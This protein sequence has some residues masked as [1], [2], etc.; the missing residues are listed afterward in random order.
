M[1]IERLDLVAFGHFTDDVIDLS[2]GPVRFHLVYGPNESGKSTSL[3]AIHSLLFGMPARSDDDFIHPYRSM[4]VGGRLVDSESG[5]AIDCV[6]RRGKKKTLLTPDEQS[7]LDPAKLA[8]MLR[9]V[10]SETFS[11]QFGISHAELVAGGRAILEGGGDLGEMLFAAGSGTGALRK[12]RQRLEEDMRE[13]FIPR[14]SRGALNRLLAEHQENQRQI[15][16]L[17]LLPRAYEEKL[18]EF[19]RALADAAETEAQLKAE[20]R[21]ERRLRAIAA[22]VERLPERESIRSELAAIGD[23]IP[24]LDDD[25]RERRRDLQEEWSDI[26]QSVATH[27]QHAEDLQRQRDAQPLDPGWNEVAPDIKRLMNQLSEIESEEDELTPLRHE[28]QRAEREADQTR[29]RLAANDVDS[30]TDGGNNPGAP[31]NVPTRLSDAARE[32]INDLATR[33]GGLAEQLRAAEEAESELNQLLKSFTTELDRLPTPPDPSPLDAAITATPEPRILLDQLTQRRT[34]CQRAHA[35]ALAALRK[36]GG[37][38]GTLDEAQRLVLPAESR[39]A[40]LAK[41]I[42][43]AEAAV[44]R[45]GVECESC[46]RRR[47]DAEAEW[48]EAAED[49]ELP[50]WEQRDAARLQRD[51]TVATLRRQADSGQPI[52]SAAI[53]TLAA[54]IRCVDEIADA[55]YRAHDRVIRRNALAETLRRANEEVGKAVQSRDDAANGLADANAD[56]DALWSECG[57]NAGGPEAMRRW[58]IDHT[59]VI[60]L[61]SQWQDSQTAVAEASE[62]IGHAIDHLHS[63]LRLTAAESTDRQASDAEP[64]DDG[65]ERLLRLHA[66]ARL[67]L[68][69]WNQQRLRRDEAERRRDE[70]LARLREATTRRE[71]Q[72]RE[73]DRWQTRWDRVIESV[74]GQP[75]ARPETIQTTLRLIDRLQTLADEAEKLR[76]RID[77]IETKRLDY[78][79]RAEAVA[80]AR[81]IA[82]TATDFAKIVRELS[83]QADEQAARNHQRELL[84]DQLDRKIDEITKAEAEE[85]RL[86]ARLMTLCDEAG[87]EAIESLPQIEQESAHRRELETRFAAIDQQ[88]RGLAESEPLDEFLADAAGYDPATLGIEIEKATAE[89]ARLHGVWVAA[90]QSIGL[91]RGEVASMDGSEAAARLQQQQQNLVA[92]IRRLADRYAELAIAD[93]MLRRSIDL[94]REQNQGPVLQRAAIHFSRMTGGEYESLQVD[95]DDKGKPRLY[96]TRPER[97]LPVLASLM[98]DGTADALYLSLRLAS[99]EVHLD[100]H[101]PVPLIVD[102]CLIQFDD[103]RAAA[104]LAI[105]SEM[106]GRTQV[107]LFTHHQHLLELAA[108]TLPPEGFHVQQLRKGHRK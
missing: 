15:R 79:G 33:H 77:R 32:E 83:R 64:A 27:R 50:T 54:E 76:H 65:G 103:D 39:I 72:Q 36:L 87:C 29:Q 20:T 91:L 89:K 38:A 18:K 37:F 102:D 26:R 41:R 45:A 53:E 73:W 100:T 52:A 68:D 74:I 70:T 81:G 75:D 35:K 30:V 44:G 61:A 47:D 60:E 58:V 71:R 94:Y 105:L 4:R 7:E 86:R 66:M 12:V 88:L 107:I 97:G 17:Q 16:Q 24:L 21:R 59:T 84:S 9:G 55:L 13:L 96:G 95:F 23:S 99:L 67:R 28:L 69:Q 11:R 43:R 46:Q 34:D 51:E 2:G 25:F 31:A 108:E 42:E 40:E 104:A 1:I 106:A 10:D 80:R 48:K 98:S 8:A 5:A 22:A 62:R 101:H 92:K 90:E 85:Q 6:R 78:F 82:W 63:A 56:W 19:D 57:V 14:G 93:E 3:R 49:A